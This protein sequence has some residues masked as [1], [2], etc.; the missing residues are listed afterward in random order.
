MKTILFISLLIFSLIGSAAIY[1]QTD[2]N[3]QV[4]YSDTPTPGAQIITLSG[5]TPTPTTASKPA[6][7]ATTSAPPTSTTDVQ[8][9][10]REEIT[11]RV[12]YTKFMIDSPVD[13]QTI[14]NQNTI[15]VVLLL[16]PGLQKGDTAQ[17][18]VDG[19][20]AGSPAASTNLELPRIDR[21]THQLYAVLLDENN[22]PLK[23]SQ[24][25]TVY[26]HYAQVGGPP[27]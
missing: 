20:A 13:N 18:Y 16:S 27:N 26:I 9:A 3:G 2:K 12:P 7:A 24:T 15:P 1:M 6:H 14:T 23:Q 19:T 17:I 11:P 5:T 22:H 4:T 10:T 8:A 25:I 21:G